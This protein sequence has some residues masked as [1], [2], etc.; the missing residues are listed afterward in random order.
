MNISDLHSAKGLKFKLRADKT[1]GLKD[2]VVTIDKTGNSL[3]FFVKTFNGNTNLF[4]AEKKTARNINELL[5]IENNHGYKNLFVVEDMYPENN[6]YYIEVQ[7]YTFASITDYKTPITIQVPEIINQKNETNKLYDMFVYNGIGMPAIFALRYNNN[8]KTDIRLIAGNIFL[9]IKITSRGFIIEKID[10]RRDR[11]IL[12]I[13]MY[14]APEIEFVPES[15]KAGNNELFAKDLDTFSSAASYFSRWE[16]YN[17]LAKKE[18]IARSEEFG[19]VPYTGYKRHT[20]EGGYMFTFYINDEIDKSYLGETIGIYNA[21]VDR[22]GNPQD[23]WAGKITKIDNDKIETLLERDVIVDIPD[24]GNLVL[25]QI[26]DI[27]IIKRR[28]K[29]KDRMVN[30]KSPIKYIVPL[31]EKG[32]SEFSSESN[33]TNNKSI[34]AELEKNFKQAKNL[35]SRQKEALELAINT[36]DIALIQGPPGTGKTTVIKAI[37]ERFREIFERDNNGERPTILISS[38]QNDAVDNAVSNPIPGELPA[39][40]IGKKREEYYKKITED[41]VEKVE[42]ELV[43]RI[44]NNKTFEFGG[45]SSRLS[46]D[47]FVYKHTGEKPIDGI[48]LIEEY[49]SIPG[50]K[51]PEPLKET[52]NKIITKYQ[53]HGN[54]TIVINEDP[55]FMCLKEQRLTKEGFNDDGFEK[56]KKLRAHLRIRSDLNIEKTYLDAINAAADNGIN[57]NDVFKKYK[58]SVNALIKIFIPASDQFNPVK[59]NQIDKCLQEL[60]FAF[61]NGRLNAADILDDKKALI[62]GDFLERF[63]DEA[64]T[65]IGKYSLTTAATCQLSMPLFGQ[66]EPS[67]DM[68][69]VDEAARAIPLD[70]FIPMSMG[71][72]II[73]V[74]DHKQLPHMLEPEVLKLIMDDPQYKDLPQLDISLFERLFTMFNSGIRPKSI[75]LKIQFRMHPD[76]CRFVSEAF[77]ENML[78]SGISAEDRVIPQDVF[79][80]RALVYVNVSRKNDFEKGGMS[81][82]R[83]SEAHYIAIDIKKLFDICPDKK[84]GVITFYSAQKN[85]LEEEIRKVLNDNQYSKVELG[86]VDA[87][88]GKEF[89]YVFLSCVRSNTETEEKKSVGFLVKE[90]RICVAL[91]RAKYQL[92]IYGDAQTINAVKCFKLLYEKCKNMNEG[93]YC[94]Y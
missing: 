89:D 94:E 74:G 76:I 72:K 15:S 48:K 51:Y 1:T 64:D 33:W 32:A 92:A 59:T 55:F 60:A 82:F 5:E 46:D 61:Y 68:V 28:E 27:S 50:I 78:E 70:L 80:G 38:F 8:K 66:S 71:K 3:E 11:T 84:V 87:F 25:S 35:N 63:K 52:A 90:N 37:C 19:K 53:Q 56:V 75:L 29:A 54:S 39:Y 67:Y 77:Y 43:Q 20:T 14:L 73:L 22:R 24:S 93:Y 30:R 18:L 81:K 34:T 17:E 4:T 85:I 41:W 57:D 62:I 45:I 10:S 16:A 9:N 23:I 58:E 44:N 6:E 49:L 69:I 83:V 31:I 13:D 21:A 36:P 88:Q 12:P 86:T 2:A 91:S 26:G 47:Y 40:R 7:S 65:L 42:A 79:G